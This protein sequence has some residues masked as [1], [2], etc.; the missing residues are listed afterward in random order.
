MPKQRQFDWW[1]LLFKES[2]ENFVASPKQI[3]RTPVAKG[4]RL[5]AWPAFF[6][7]NK[8]LTICKAVFDV[9]PAG[10]FSKKVP[11]IV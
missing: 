5:P 6:A 7:L 4:S 1:Y 11:S 10:L 2:A 9:M 8:R 3:G